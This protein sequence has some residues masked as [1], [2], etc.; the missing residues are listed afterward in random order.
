MVTMSEINKL[1]ADMLKEIEQLR[2]G[3]NALSE[4]KTS[5]VDPE[6]IKASKKLDDALNEYAR[7]SSKWQEPPTGQV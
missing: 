4:N 1:L 6:L 2:I 5:L 7:L 3:L